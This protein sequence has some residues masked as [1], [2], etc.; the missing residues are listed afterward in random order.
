LPGEELLPLSSFGFA[1]LDLGSEASF[2]L[3]S[4]PFEREVVLL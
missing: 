2:A 3:A 4:V 1:R